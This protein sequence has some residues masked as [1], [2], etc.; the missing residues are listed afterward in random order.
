MG[1]KGLVRGPQARGRG[2]MTLIEVAIAGSV[3]VIGL[4]GFLRVVVMSIG[5]GA[6]NREADLAT[7]AA[8][9]TIEQLQAANFDTLQDTYGVPPGGG[10]PGN[11][12]AV[13][14]LNPD[15][16]DPDGLVG[17]IIMPVLVVGGAVQVREDLKM[18]ELGMPRDLNGYGG[19]DSLDHAGDKLIMPVLV[20]LRWRGAMGV[21]R[22]EFRT[23][24]A[25]Y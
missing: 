15:P 1:A 19:F 7:Q 11:A 20:R 6:A 12:F 9:Q 25:P 13:P 22:M 16:N 14:G 5:S 23:M 18:P 4:L 17:E 24:V 10:V 2:G 8:K 3:M 21:S